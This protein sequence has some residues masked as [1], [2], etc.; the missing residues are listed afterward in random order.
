MRND[1][2]F[3]L[4]DALLAGALLSISAVAGLAAMAQ[5]NAAVRRASGRERVAA[6]AEEILNVKLAGI[7]ASDGACQQSRED[8]DE[9]MA[10]VR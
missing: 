9:A 4:M 7:S 5:A 6:C 3:L 10:L 8:R 1:R 2:G